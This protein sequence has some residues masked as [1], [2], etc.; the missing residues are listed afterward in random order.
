MGDTLEVGVSRGQD[1]KTKKWDLTARSKGKM[2]KTQ[3]EAFTRELC[4]LFKKYKLK[5]PP[6][7]KWPD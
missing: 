5:K 7:L 3:W 6:S 4:A 1:P 2:T